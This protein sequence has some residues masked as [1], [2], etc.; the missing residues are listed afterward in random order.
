[1]CHQDM[2]VNFSKYSSIHFMSRSFLHCL[3]R[4][5]TLSFKNLVYTRVVLNLFHGPT[6]QFTNRVGW[7][8]IAAEFLSFPSLCEP[9]QQGRLW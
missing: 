5:D 2:A 1:M 9:T 6:N 7:E 8:G 4:M 3:V